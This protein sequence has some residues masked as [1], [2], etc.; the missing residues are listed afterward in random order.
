MQ[1][2]D[3]EE[4]QYEED[5]GDYT[6]ESGKNVYYLVGYFLLVAILVYPATRFHIGMAGILYAMAGAGVVLGLIWWC[7]RSIKH[8]MQAMH[9][10]TGEWA[11]FLWGYQAAPIVEAD[12]HAPGDVQ[13][14]PQV[15]R[16]QAST[17]TYHGRSVTSF[18]GS[19]TPNR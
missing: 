4:Q 19:L 11:R 6:R 17:N 15:T 16:R 12:G 10:S 8:K 18:Q 5:F 2:Q 7:I 13:E 9:L 1:E 14:A 3:D